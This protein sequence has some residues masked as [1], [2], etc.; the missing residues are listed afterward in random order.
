[1]PCYTAGLYALNKSCFSS[2]ILG[3]YPPS[4]ALALPVTEL[5]LPACRPPA[6]SLW[7]RPSSL[8]PATM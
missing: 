2:S 3:P 7:L 5:H 8:E 6:Q 4:T 1:M